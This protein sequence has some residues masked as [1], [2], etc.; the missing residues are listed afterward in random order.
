VVGSAY[1]SVTFIRTLRRAW[2]G[3]ATPL[4]IG[5]ITVST[6]V[7]LAVGRPVAIL[8]VVGAINAMILPLGLGA[9]LVAAN[10]RDVVPGYRHP[11][12]LT[13]AGSAV[14][15]VMAGLGVYTLVREVPPL[16]R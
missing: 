9:M 4:T 16:F 2:E 12:A 15:L 3:L 1:T 6:A 13:V 11:A 5:F 10:R 14:A 8:I 7:F